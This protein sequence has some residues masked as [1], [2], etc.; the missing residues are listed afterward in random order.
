MARPLP[1]GKKSVDL[2]AT[3]SVRVSR[4]RRDPP[5][6]VKAKEVTIADRDQRDAWIVVLGVITFALAIAVIVVGVGGWTGFSPREY[7][8][9]L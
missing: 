2:A 8:V 9:H 5:P 7:T 3:G 4:I 1:S 6:K